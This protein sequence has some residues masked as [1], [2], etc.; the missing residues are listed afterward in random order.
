M[1]RFGKTGL[2]VL[3][4]LLALEVAFRFLPVSNGY[5]LADVT[6]EMPVA[7]RVPNDN[8]TLSDGWLMENAVTRRVNNAGFVNATDYAFNSDVPV[9]ALI[10]DSQI[11]SPD[12]PEEDT[13]HF[14]LRDA[15]EGDAAV[16]TFAMS[17]APLTQYTVWARHAVAHYVPRHLVFFISPNDF[18]ES[19]DQ[20]GLFPGFHYLRA[21]G[22]DLTLILREYRQGW[23]S[24]AAQHSALIAYLVHNVGVPDLIARAIGSEGTQLDAQGLTMLLDWFFAELAAIGIDPS[25]TVFVLNPSTQSHYDAGCDAPG[26]VFVP[27]DAFRSAAQ[28]NGFATLDASLY[29]CEWHLAT[30]EKLE[31]ADGV[32][33]NASGH[34]AVANLLVQTY[35]GAER[36]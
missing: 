30:G 2:N 26:P 16:Y 4:L 24:Q 9:I 33:W 14:R 7:R 6:P 15:M 25:E 28:D 3:A 10:G 17:G 35:F 13:V 31:G 8:A 32:H 19:F 20:F 18:D 21:E 34:N 5:F 29:F 36:D 23:G 12:I 27:Y 11:E 22:G 1:K